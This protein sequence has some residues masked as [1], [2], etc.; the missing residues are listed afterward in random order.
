MKARRPARWIALALAAMP[1]GGCGII[2][3]TTKAPV[4]AVMAVV[5]GSKSGQIDPAVL[6]VEVQRYADEFMSQTVSAIDEYAR[7][8]GTGEAANQ[9]LRWKIAL[10]TSVV[11]LASGPSPF[12]SMVDMVTVATI[13]RSVLEEHWVKTP[14]GPAFQPWLESSRVLEADGWKLASGVL[15]PEQQ[16]ALRQVI[17][18]WLES[19]PGARIAFFARPQEFSVVVREATH[20]A[21]STS[22]IIGLL[23]LDPTLGLDPAV[24]EVTRTRLL[25]ER[26][27][28][29]F[30]RMPYIIRAQVELLV[31]QFVRGPEVSKALTEASRLTES[32]DRISRAM[33]SASQTA[34]QLP[35]R[36]TDERKAILAELEAQEGKLRDLSAEVERTLAAGERMSTSLNTTITTFDALMKRFGVGEPETETDAAPDPGAKPFDILEFAHTAE[37][38]TAMAKELDALIKDAA[39]TVD[40]PALEKRFQD[41]GAVAER[42]TDDARSLLNHAFLLGTGLVVLAFACALAYRWL[43]PRGPRSRSTTPL[44]AQRTLAD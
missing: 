28:Y 5:P 9:A 18:R 25:M 16:V 7:M 32:A 34:A 35:D 37:K 17:A 29:T 19:N 21:P 33:E 2:E 8:V 20:K 30:Q 12:A 3:E 41:L 44:G 15:S 4:K 14:D 27:M 36:I 42:A 23:G 11:S 24:R 26:A 22:G 13:M 1:A 10:V 39:S 31:D 40:S 6:Q 43:G 38:V